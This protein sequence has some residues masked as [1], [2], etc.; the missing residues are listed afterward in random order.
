MCA[1]LGEQLF[2][3]IG[4][5]VFLMFTIQ[6]AVPRKT[7]LLLINQD[8]MV[9]LLVQFVELSLEPLLGPQEFVNFV[10]GIHKERG[11]GQCL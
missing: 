11:M 10:V 6:R 4:L 1:Q 2:P 8:D 3:E 7:S 5:C 9:Q